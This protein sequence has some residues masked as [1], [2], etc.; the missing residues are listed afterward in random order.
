MLLLA[1]VLFTSC[2]KDKSIPGIGVDSVSLNQKA[3]SIVVGESVT[4]KATIMPETAPVK[5][6]NWITCDNA[7]AT[8]DASGAVKGIAV[9]EAVITAISVD[10]GKMASCT[11]TVKASN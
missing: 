9:G 8:V 6:V 2:E 11:V 10:G 4:L 5:D 7:I 3:I 1:A